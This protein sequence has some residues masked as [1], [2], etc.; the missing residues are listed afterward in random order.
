MERWLKIADD[1][2]IRPESVVSAMVRYKDPR[3]PPE[4]ILTLRSTE[5]L[6]LHSERDKRIPI[7]EA[8]DLP[9]EWAWSKEAQ[10][11]QS[12]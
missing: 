12:A 3:D 5:V 10:Q 2:L 1:I 7:L 8:L 11:K 6:M 9:R 4:I